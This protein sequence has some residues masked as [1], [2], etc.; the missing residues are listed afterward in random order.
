MKKYEMHARFDCFLEF[1][2]ISNV[3]RI[4]GG[5]SLRDANTINLG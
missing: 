1:E 4:R 3:K 2:E 5:L